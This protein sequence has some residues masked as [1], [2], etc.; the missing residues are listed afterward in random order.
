M[1]YVTMT[2]KF[3]SKLTGGKIDKYIIE[4]QN[5]VD[6]NKIANNAAKRPEMK[7]I[8]I[9]S[10]KIPYYSPSKFVVTIQKFENLGGKWLD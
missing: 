3:L 4:C 9:V 2:D 7:Y 6:A 5:L 8:N 10:G 1:F